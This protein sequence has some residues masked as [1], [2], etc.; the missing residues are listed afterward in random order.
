MEIYGEFTNY[1][2]QRLKFGFNSDLLSVTLDE[3]DTYCRFNEEATVSIKIQNGTIIESKCINPIINHSSFC[4]EIAPHNNGGDA[5]SILRNDEIVFTIPKRFT[6]KQMKCFQKF[7]ENDIFEL[8][9]GGND[10][11]RDN[12]LTASK[13][14]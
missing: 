2:K 11:V 10:G 1:D 14:Y 13:T 3:D 12:V 7:E 5:I 8:K 4:I 6:S 9:N